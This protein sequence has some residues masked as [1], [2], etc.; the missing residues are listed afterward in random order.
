MIAT[1][2][3]TIVS[4]RMSPV[5]MPVTFVAVA[6]PMTFVTVPMTFMSVPMPVT[7]GAVPMTMTFMAVPV[8]LGAVSM[9]VTFV[10]VSVGV[11]VRGLY[12]FLRGDFKHLIINRHPLQAECLHIHNLLQINTR[13]RRRK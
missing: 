3:V 13:F 2:I 10:S 8:T 9:P 7:F 5:P 11:G 4:M 12:V 6:M 1:V